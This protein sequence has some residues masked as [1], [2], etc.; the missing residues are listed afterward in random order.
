TPLSFSSSITGKTAKRCGF[1]PTSTP[2]SSTPRC[3]PRKKR[4]CERSWTCR[5][6]IASCTRRTVQ[7][8]PPARPGRERP[9]PRQIGDRMEIQQ[10]T[11]ERMIRTPEVFRQNMV[12]SL[13]YSRGANAQSASPYDIYMALSRTVRN[14]LVDRFRRTVDM[15]YAVNPRFV[16]YLSAE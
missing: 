1:W 7:R 12:N 14:H 10:P 9:N 3:S 16:Y 5:V 13:Y 8:R 2:P 6:S 15:R 11:T 4:D